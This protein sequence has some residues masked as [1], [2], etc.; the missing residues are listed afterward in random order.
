MR[1]LPKGDAVALCTIAGKPRI[2]EHCVQYAYMVQ[3]DQTE[4]W[5]QE[6]DPEYKKLAVDKD[7]PHHMN[8][9]W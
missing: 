5:Q 4:T 9:I 8:W 3:W 1:Q 7:N 2:P 6:K